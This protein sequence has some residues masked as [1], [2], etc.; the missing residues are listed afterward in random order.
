ME[1][2]SLDKMEDKS[3]DNIND[4]GTYT[5]E[6]LAWKLLVDENIN[7][8]ATIAFTDSKE[9]LFEILIIIYIEMVFSYYRLNY[10]MEHDNADNFKLDL[11]CV[12]L[13][14]LTNVFSEKINKIKF[15]LNI[16]EILLEEYE[17]IK[18]DR[19][20]TILLK[21]SPSD[22][23][24]FFANEE[25][26]GPDKRYHFVLNSQYVPRTELRDIFCTVKINNKYYK[27]SFMSMI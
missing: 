6:E 16:H 20:C 5:P 15:L 27:I 21:D 8:T 18:W 2:K 13:E 12:N 26:L 3:L 19:Y 17:Y 23:I 9:T 24:Y 10:L 7:D 25:I 4:L 14:S 1:D 22:S 11:T